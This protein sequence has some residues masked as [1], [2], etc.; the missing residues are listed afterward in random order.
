MNNAL[1]VILIFFVLFFFSSCRTSEVE[2]PNNSV[3]LFYPNY[4]PSPVYKFE[5]NKLTQEGIQLGRMLFYDPI[6]SSDSA[7]SCGSCHSQAHA[8]ADHNMKVSVGV[9][10]RVGSRNSPPIFN[11]AWHP[12]F[13]WDGG[14]NHLEVVPLA[15]ITNH[16]EMDDNIPNILIK[17]NRNT[18]YI[19][20]FEKVFNKTIIDDQMLFFALAQFMGSITSFESKYDHVK[21]GKA[22]FTQNEKLGYELFKTNCNSCH[23]EPLFT[24]FTFRNNGLD[25]VFIDKGRASITLLEKEEGLFKVPSLRNVALT[26][27]YMH[28][29]RF[30]TLDDVILH[31]NSGIRKSK[32]LDYL[33]INPIVLNSKER[34]DI[35]AFLKTLN[36]YQLINQSNI[37][38]P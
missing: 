18:S 10:G 4:I 22:T 5:N 7:I 3:G 38:E 14:V 6:L 29:G 13:M 23:Q 20:W 1:K 11:L 28:D 25:S 16:F 37:S 15:P 33:L 32:T 35:I 34:Q 17:L 26:Y 31:Y 12:H 21:Q 8:F 30:R 19:A 24:D 36:D 27:P 2:Q 9:G